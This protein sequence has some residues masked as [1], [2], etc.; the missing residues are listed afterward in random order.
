V[1]GGGVIGLS[2]A[3]EAAGRGRAVCLL[4]Q[5]QFGSEASWAGAG[6]LPPGNLDK[7]ANPEAKLRALSHRLWP[8][9][10]EQLRDET[11]I[12]NG[13]L[14]CGGI[15]VEMESSASS[16]QRELELRQSEGVVVEPLTKQRLS[17]LEPALTGEVRQA[18]L[19]PQLAQVRNPRHLKALIAACSARGVELHTGERVT[20][21]VTRNG[22]V[23]GVRTIHGE[24]A[25]EAV[26]L[27]G[28]AWSSDLLRKHGR[29]V[30]IVP[31]RGQIVLL[32]LSSPPFRHVLECGRRYLVP[33]P[34]GRVLIGS[35]EE[36]V[37][38]DKRNTAAAVSELI[39]FATRLVPELAEA[40]LE[41]TWAGLRPG[42]P[43]GLPFLGPVPEM[44]GLF[45]AAGH[46]RSGLQMSTGTAAVMGDLICGREPQIPLA[47][48]LI[49]GSIT[50]SA[51]PVA[52]SQRTIS[53]GKPSRG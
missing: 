42:N 26:C 53:T 27:A 39:A 17:K 23:H 7:A 3:C 20:E 1:I 36:H 19:L 40:T 8:E 32:S 46:F 4:E 49:D 15:A 11:G 5:G 43:R 9:W 41:R 16:L 18:F 22:R 6:I 33:R 30:E 51:S 48:F 2:I 52:R 12:D 31:V 14:P 10:S 25:A 13:Y 28:G 29:T 45:I 21:L 50:A 34:D 24:R 47:G 37:G 38:F 35:T 44:D